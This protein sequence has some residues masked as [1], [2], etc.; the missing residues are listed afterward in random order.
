MVIANCLSLQV[1]TWIVYM[2]I[3]SL[4]NI[5]DCLWKINKKARIIIIFVIKICVFYGFLSFNAVFIF[6]NQIENKKQY[7]CVHGLVLSSIVLSIHI[8]LMT[9]DCVYFGYFIMHK[10]YSAKDINKFAPQHARFMRCSEMNTSNCFFSKKCWSLNLEHILKCHDE[11]YDPKKNLW[12]KLTCRGNY[13]IG[14]HQTTPQNAVLISQIGFIPGKR[15]M[16]GGGIYFARTVNVT[17]RKA[18]KDRK[19]ALI[20]AL[21]DMGRMK[22]VERADNS[23]T[24]QSLNNQGYDTVYA[25]KGVDLNNDEFVVYE[26][27]RIKEWIVVEDFENYSSND[28]ILIQYLRSN[29]HNYADFTKYIDKCLV[30]D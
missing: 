26:S 23:I 20:A 22:I 16:F 18:R 5:Q 21:V 3:I 12:Y 30:Y 24:L 25:T 17:H 15:G 2:F 11:L 27:E 6:K 28:S 10:P 8:L 29:N 1:L 7:G 4:L 14:F 13:L 9:W 19:G